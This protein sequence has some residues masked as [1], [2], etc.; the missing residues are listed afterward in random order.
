MWIE[1][2]A[3]WCKLYTTLYPL[4]VIVITWENA[5]HVGEQVACICTLNSSLSNC[6]TEPTYIASGTYDVELEEMPLLCKL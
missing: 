6:V 5:R 4:H 1:R 2:F 3:N